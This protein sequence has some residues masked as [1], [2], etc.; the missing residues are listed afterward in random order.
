M[1]G[2]KMT[3][4]SVKGE[5]TAVK[6]KLEFFEAQIKNHAT[7]ALHH[8]TVD[9][10]IK[11]ADHWRQKL[12]DGYIF[13]CEL[14]PT[15]LEVHKTEYLELLEKTRKVQHLLWDITATFPTTTSSIPVAK[16]NLKLPK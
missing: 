13:I 7:T 10:Y 16:Q 11:E 15:D 4:D 8:L 9:A 1:A 14:E 12:D 5:R 6:T 3:E 2:R